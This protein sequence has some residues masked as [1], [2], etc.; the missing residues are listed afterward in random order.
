MKASG[1]ELIL[2]GFIAVCALWWVL[3]LH[4]TNNLRLAE[5]RRQGGTW[6]AVST[7]PYGTDNMGCIRHGRILVLPERITQ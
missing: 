2:V 7:T 3:T 5:C 1:T 6:G 4:E